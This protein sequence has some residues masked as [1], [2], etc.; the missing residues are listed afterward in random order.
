MR[1]ATL[2]IPEKLSFTQAKDFHISYFFKVSEIHCSKEKLYKMIYNS[3]SEPFACQCKW[4]NSVHLFQANPRREDT[5][6]RNEKQHLNLIYL[7]QLLSPSWIPVY[8]KV[9]LFLIDICYGIFIIFPV[10]LQSFG[11]SKFSHVDPLGSHI[12]H[13]LQVPQHQFSRKPS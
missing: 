1:G 9:L 3:P 4:L 7:M 6:F 5:P 10:S 11:I 2:K 12:K 13:L 8:F